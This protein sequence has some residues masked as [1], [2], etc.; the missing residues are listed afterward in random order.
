MYV[1]SSRI[2]DIE[3]IKGWL[4]DPKFSTARKRM[5]NDT[6]KKIQS[7]LHDKTLASKRERLIKATKAE[8]TLE[9]WKITNQIKDYSKEELVSQKYEWV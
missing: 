5:F 7:Q 6:L 2:K 9:M 3:Q 1:D 8:D 4:A